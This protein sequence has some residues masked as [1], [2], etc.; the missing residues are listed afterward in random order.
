VKRA[1][2]RKVLFGSDG[3]WL[4]PGVELHKIKLLGLPPEKEALILGG[5]ALRVLKRRPGAP[6]VTAGVK[7]RSR[8]P[9]RWRGQTPA[10]DGR[11]QPAAQPEHEL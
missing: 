9:E 11:L 7:E 2:A 1:G 6:R 8:R 3:P 4:H 10:V 5:N